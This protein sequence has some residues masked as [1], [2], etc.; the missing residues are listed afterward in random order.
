MDRITRKA[1]ALALA[2]A[3]SVAQADSYNDTEGFHGYVRAGAGTSNK[4]GPQSCFGLGGPTSSYRLGNECDSYTEFGYTHELARADNGVS[5]VGTLWTYAY[6]PGS[7]F[8]DASMRIA[9]AYVEARN[10]PFLNGG[11]AWVGKRYYYR[12]DIHM[13]DM[14]YINMNGTGGGLDKIPFGPGKLSYAVFKDSDIN[15]AAAGSGAIAN[16]PSALRQNLLYEGLPVN[17]G[18]AIDIALTYVTPQGRDKSAEGLGDFGHKGWAVGLF[19]RQVIL[20]GANVF[21]LQYGVGPGTGIGQCC[22]RMGAAGST[23]IGREVTRARVFN[24]LVIQ[25]SR[26][27]SM[28][29]AALYQQDKADDPALRNRWATLGVRPVYAVLSNLK[30]Q[31]ELG[32]TILKQESTG[33]TARLTKLTLAPAIALG[34]SYWSRPELRLYVSYGRWNGAATPLV[35]AS[36]NGGPVYANSTSGTSAGVQVESWW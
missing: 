32:Q 1:L 29:F 2:F 33:Q 11:T 5:F 27:F 4:H 30:L 21:G 17:P 20:G 16:T 34:E 19:H 23:S 15:H 25:P 10:L 7:D 6:A 9:K 14:Q 26:R 35:N 3:C 13:L 22:A 18:G 31:A 8:G 24:D 36:N 28:E 12:P